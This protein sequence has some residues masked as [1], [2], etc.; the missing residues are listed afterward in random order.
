[1]ASTPPGSCG[2]DLKPVAQQLAL[3]KEKIRTLI[4]V[5]RADLQR[6]RW[7]TTSGWQLASGLQTTLRSF[8]GHARSSTGR[9]PRC[10]PGA[11]PAPL[12]RMRCSLADQLDPTCTTCRTRSD[13]FPDALRSWRRRRT[14]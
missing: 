7:R 6:D 5:A 12:Q 9:W 10:R 14:S 4:T 13:E 1:V 3:R 8:G 2:N 11:Q